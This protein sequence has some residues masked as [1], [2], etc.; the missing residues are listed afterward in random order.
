MSILSA[1]TSNTTSL[2]YT[3]DTT[4]AMVFQTNGTTEAMRI[5]S[6]GNVGI[7]TSSPSA[8]TEIYGTA[9]ASSIALRVTNIAADGYSSLWLGD[10]NGALFRNG[11]T[12][13]GYAGAN[14]LNL[15]TIAAHNLGFIT[16]NTER[17]RIDSSGRVT[18]PYQPA[19]HA[20]STSIK[21]ITGSPFIFDTV[22]FNTGGH[23]NASNGR[24]TAPIAGIYYLQ[25]DFLT[26]NSNTNTVDLRF[27]KNGAQTQLGTAY[28]T[29]YTGGDHRKG[30]MIAL[31]SLNA[32]DYITVQTQS[33]GSNGNL[34]GDNNDVGG[35]GHTAFRAFLMG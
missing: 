25:M 27:F 30:F 28:Y 17:M 10:T 16:N 21:E 12:Q 15:G 29:N 24:F 31:A 22:F 33:S 6:S 7:G 13:T 14:S 32:N 18:M 23:Y 8:K 5:D 1:G 4:G 35:K 11:S 3:G 34:Y 20:V 9:A 19:F 2:I 26:T